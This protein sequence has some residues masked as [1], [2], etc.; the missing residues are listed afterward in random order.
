MKNFYYI[1]VVATAF[2]LL[3][4]VCGV[5][6]YLNT[7]V[8]EGYVGSLTFIDSGTSADNDKGFILTGLV[9]DALLSDLSACLTHTNQGM[10][11][12][13]EH[14]EVYTFCG[15]ILFEADSSPPTA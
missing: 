15:C 12:H 3:G 14:I 11:Y 1:F 8:E 7:D 10:Q 5:A 2:L 9:Y 4:K 13:F 6:S